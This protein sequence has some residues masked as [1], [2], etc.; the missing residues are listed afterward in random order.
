MT[1]KDLIGL[2]KGMVSIPSFSREEGP[3][4]DYIEGWLR[5]NGLE[6]RRIGNNIRENDIQLRYGRGFDH[7]W[8]LDGEGMRSVCLVEDP[9]SGRTVEIIT[10]QKGLQFYSGNFF[11]GKDVGKNGKPIPFRSALTLEARGLRFTATSAHQPLVEK[12]K[13]RT[14]R[15]FR[16]QSTPAAIRARPKAIFK[17]CFMVNSFYGGQR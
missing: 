17:D 13:V 11:D 12:S 15:T 3:V 16:I 14:P 4:A 2:L 9:V 5:A 10:D 8:C 6:P 1:D 7:N